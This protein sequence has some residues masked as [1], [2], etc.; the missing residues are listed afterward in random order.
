YCTACKSCSGCKHCAKNG[1][2]CGVC[3]GGRNYSSSKSTSKSVSSYS[4]VDTSKF[5]IGEKVLVNSV[6][7]NLRRGP[8]TQYQ[9]IEKL[10]ITDKL[11]VLEIIGSWLKVKVEKT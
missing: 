11:E 10:S 5:S 1:G 4:L 8:G 7:L 3:S 2:S 6:T 9:I